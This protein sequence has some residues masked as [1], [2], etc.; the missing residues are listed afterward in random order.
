MNKK[1]VE[2]E[3]KIIA[4]A[5]AEGN[6]VTRPFKQTIDIEWT[7]KDLIDELA[8]REK[9]VSDHKKMSEAELTQASV[10]QVHMAHLEK[11][12]NHPA[13]KAQVDAEAEYLKS[14]ATVKTNK[15]ESGSKEN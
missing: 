5:E 10:H 12:L 11:V 6:P 15:D 1:N 4:L 7:A 13:V 9:L 2:E 8:R 14:T 3:L